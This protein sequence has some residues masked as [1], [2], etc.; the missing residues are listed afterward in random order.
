MPNGTSPV[1]CLPESGSPASLAASA[2]AAAAASSDLWATCGW[3]VVLAFACGLLLGLLVLLFDRCVL[4]TA[5]YAK[6]LGHGSSQ[7]LMGRGGS[8]RWRAAVVSSN[9]D[10]GDGQGGGGGSNSNSGSSSSTANRGALQRA[11]A[12]NAAQRLVGGRR[13]VGQRALPLP[14]S[15]GFSHSAAWASPTC[16]AAMRRPDEF[17]LSLSS[18]VGGCAFAGAGGSLQSP[19]YGVGAPCLATVLANPLSERSERLSPEAPVT[20]I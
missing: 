13:P 4:R 11:A 10:G 18:P 6:P 12:A 3:Q 15:P 16:A 2:A 8:G 5:P 17:D 19:G 1:L 14:P 9:G 7:K 20:R